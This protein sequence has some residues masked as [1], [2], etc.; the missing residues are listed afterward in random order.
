MALDGTY[1]GLLAS[2]ASW[3][4]RSDMTAIIPD[5][6]VLAEARIARDLRLRRQV[7][8]ATLATIAATQAVALPSDYLE[9]ENLSLTSGGVDNSL[10][11]I[12]I[13]RM[14]LNYPAGNGDGIPVVYTFEGSNILLGPRPDAVYSMPIYYYARMAALTVTPT[15]WLLT[16][17]PNIYLFGALAEAGDWVQDTENVAKWEAKYKAGV[18][19]L[20][21]SDDNS[22][23]SGAALRVRSK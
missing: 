20:T 7:T 6:V 18:A 13:E 3:L 4:H 22:M 10:E 19:A 5:L 2:V 12:N 9:M 16:N 21:V 1:T 14:N 17:H 23:F 15:N 8:S 11:Y